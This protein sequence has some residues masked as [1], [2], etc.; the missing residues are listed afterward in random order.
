MRDGERSYQFTHERAA[1]EVALQEHNQVP[2][3]QEKSTAENHHSRLP[4]N[5]LVESVETSR[6]QHK[7]AHIRQQRKQVYAQRNSRFLAKP[8]EESLQRRVRVLVLVAVRPSSAV[9]FQVR[10]VL[11]SQVVGVLALV[12]LVVGLID[13]GERVH[14]HVVEGGRDVAHEGHEE[15][16][17]LQDG[18][19]DEVDAVDDVG[20]PCHLGEVDEEAEELDEE[21]DADGLDGMLVCG[22]LYGL[23]LIA[24][25]YGEKDSDHYAC[26]HGQCCLLVV[27]AGEQA[28]ILECS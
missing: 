1:G 9:Q 17:H 4:A 6:R 22:V 15:E 26:Q 21:A 27:L 8:H 16:G 5:R 28:W 14:E 13:P 12:F 10:V 2:L 23:V 7:P 25:W 18:V 20:V 3:R 11:G 24:Y 19:L